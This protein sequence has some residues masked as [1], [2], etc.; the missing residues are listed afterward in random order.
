MPENME[1]GLPLFDICEAR[2][3]R[4]EESIAAHD[5]VNKKAGQSAVLGVLAHGA[6]TS[7]EIAATLG[8][9]LNCIS[10]RISELK[11]LHKI[12]KTGIRRDGAAELKLKQ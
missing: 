4:N 11:M 3:R 9:G 5:R 6:A 10:G 1:I 2:H 8:T 12:E 7:K